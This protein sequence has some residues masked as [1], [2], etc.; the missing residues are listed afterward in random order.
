MRFKHD[1]TKIF[2]DPLNVREISPQ[3]GQKFEVILSPALYWVKK[4]K[5][6]VSN[7]R[8]LQKLLPS[9]FEEFLPEGK[10]SYSAEKKGEEFIIFAYE[11]QKILAL[12]E[13]YSLHAIDIKKIVFAQ[14]VFD[15]YEGA[16]QV[17]DTQV[18]ELHDGIVVLTPATWRPDR[19][20][21]DLQKAKPTKLSIKLEQFGHI[22]DKS[23]FTKVTILLVALIF[24]LGG[25]LLITQGKIEELS[26][27]KE[28]LFSKYKLQSTMIQNK[29]ILKKYKKIYTRQK[30]IRD[31]ID[32][33]LALHLTK[34][35][36]LSVLDV[37]EKIFK[38]SIDGVD[39][40]QS[41]KI[42][43]QLKQKGVKFSAKNSNNS[44]VVE[45]KL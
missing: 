14:S 32:I 21:L 10:Y 37:N 44:M 27:A 16:M 35:Q 22:V 19:E 8:A 43:Q 18:L 15:E 9:I 5:V 1:T 12:L 3:K 41:K 33:F 39:V 7:L 2:L 45:V 30:K 29:A 11:D 36:Y 28:K 4:V 40:K 13:Q 24:A 23:S 20:P 25:E 34:E 31:L 38:M 6:P 42:A 17:N 26:R